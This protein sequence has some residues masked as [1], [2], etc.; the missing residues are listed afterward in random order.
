M[1]SYVVDASAIGIGSP[2]ID[3][4]DALFAPELIDLEIANL[5]RKAVLRHD[6]SADEAAAMLA[7]WAGNEVTRFPHAPYLGTVWTLRENI[8]AYD[9]SYVALTMHLGSQLLTGDRR[10]AAAAARFCDV[11]VV[12]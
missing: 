2:L 8:T 6:R 10:L 3:S 7:A 11:I 1:R 12:G 9:A 4:A 5:L